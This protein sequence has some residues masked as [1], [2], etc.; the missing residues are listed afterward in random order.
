MKLRI[1]AALLLLAGNPST[2]NAF[3]TIAPERPAAEAP[4]TV[5]DEA[6]AMLKELEGFVEVATWDVN[7]YRNG[8][9]TEAP[10][11]EKIT[12]READK[13]MRKEFA[14][15]LGRIDVDF[16]G[17]PKRQSAAL[18]SMLYNLGSFGPGLKAA[19]RSGDNAETVRWMA[20]YVK[21]NGEPWSGL[22]VRR[23]K[24]IAFF[25]GPKC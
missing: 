11:G 24:E 4:D 20:K 15:Y 17:L 21:V 22:R 3:L 8:H 14:E 13:R 19:I 5:T 23:A 10:K 12:R 6:L 25:L 1:L 9:G 7:A 16:P 2:A 18:A